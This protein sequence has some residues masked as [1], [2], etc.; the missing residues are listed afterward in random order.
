LAHPISVVASSTLLSASCLKL[1]NQLRR[2]YTGPALATRGEPLV[3]LADTFLV[4]FPLEFC[5]WSERA[6]SAGD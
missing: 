1:L 5:C 6:S 3:F 4:P 2:H